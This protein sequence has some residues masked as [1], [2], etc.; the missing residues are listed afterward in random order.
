[1]GVC[2]NMLSMK[3]DTLLSTRL[4]RVMW[5][6]TKIQKIHIYN[7]INYSDCYRYF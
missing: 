1:M 6:S 7:I 5:R 3:L 2:Y 4:G